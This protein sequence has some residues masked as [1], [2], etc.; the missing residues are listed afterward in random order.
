[1]VARMV[2][3]EIG[4]RVFTRWQNGFFSLHETKGDLC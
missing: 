1:M 2:S 3:L 4:E